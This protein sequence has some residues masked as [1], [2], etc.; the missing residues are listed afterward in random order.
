MAIS[1]GSRYTL[2]L[3]DPGYYPQLTIQR[4]AANVDVSWTGGRGPF[5]VMESADLSMPG[6]WENIGE[7]VTTNAVLLPL[8]PDARFLRVLDLAPRR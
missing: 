5:Q 3:V 8:G 1:A 6:A 7:P 4:K 2:A